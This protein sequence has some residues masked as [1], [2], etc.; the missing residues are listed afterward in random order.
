[1]RTSNSTS[2]EKYIRI[3]NNMAIRLLYT[4]PVSILS[5]A[6]SLMILSWLT[7]IDN[8][9]NFICSI[10]KNRHS[11]TAISTE[12]RFTINIPTKELEKLVL[13][14]GSCSGREGDKYQRLGISKKL[15]LDSFIG[16]DVE[17]V[18][19]NLCC[20]VTKI[21]DHPGHASA[22][23][24]GCV[25]MGAG[26]VGVEAAHGNAHFGTLPHL[27]SLA[28]APSPGDRGGAFAVRARAP[29]VLQSHRTQGTARRPASGFGVVVGAWRGTGFPAPRWSN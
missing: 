2:T 8:H 17:G 19:A 23:A 15:L 5:T 20:T 29:V 11:F 27:A 1:M 10:N 7:P 13:D 4:N 14:I 22:R 6:S 24:S 3:N 21:I 28:V 9:S 18:A 25:S 12:K 16:V 26:T